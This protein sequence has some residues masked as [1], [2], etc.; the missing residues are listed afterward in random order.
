[1]ID[2]E[3]LRKFGGELEHAIKCRFLEPCSTEEYINA[4]EDII[5]RTRS[6]KAW[7][8]VPIESK[9]ISKTPRE[10]KRPERPV[11]KCHKCGSTAH[12]ANTCAKKAKI[13]ELQVIEEV[14]CTEEKEEYDIDSA[15]SEDT[16]KENYPIEK[17]TAFFEVTE[18]RTHF[19]KYSDNFHNLIK[20]QDPIM[21]KTKPAKGK[22][23]TAG[24]SCITS[25]LMTDIEAKFNLDTGAFCTCVG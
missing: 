16:P 25:I 24:T 9:M 19:P 20:I 11:L 15:V 12:L 22:G 21:C 6:G 18:V 23:Y 2:M 1:M 13:N 7:I 5:T 17:I 3:V 10:D 4:M 8:R 14:Q